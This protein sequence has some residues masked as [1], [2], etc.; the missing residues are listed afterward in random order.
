VVQIGALRV[1]LVGNERQPLPAN[2]LLP[3]LAAFADAGRF[4]G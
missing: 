2:V 3:L 4:V 1:H